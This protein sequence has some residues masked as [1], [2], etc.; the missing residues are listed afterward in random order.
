MPTS[1]PDHLPTSRLIII[2]YGPQTK[3]YPASLFIMVAQLIMYRQ[4][5]TYMLKIL[6]TYRPITIQYGKQV[7]NTWLVT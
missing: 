1:T 6:P 5:Q 4:A 7:L 2:Q 3:Q